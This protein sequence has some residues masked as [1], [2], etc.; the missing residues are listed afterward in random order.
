[1]VKGFFLEKVCKIK[2]EERTK[3]EAKWPNLY[4]AIRER[5]TKGYNGIYYNINRPDVQQERNDWA[6]RMI[7]S[8]NQW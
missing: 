3:N 6:R 7:N 5:N 2:W 8:I 1:M 4:K